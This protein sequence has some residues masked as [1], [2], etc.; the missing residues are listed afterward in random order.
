[1]A[2]GEH[3]SFHVW[4]QNALLY[5]H[6]P[7]AAVHSSWGFTTLGLPFSSA[8]DAAVAGLVRDRESLEAPLN[9]GKSDRAGPARKP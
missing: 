4:I 1:M 5:V 9:P 7:E 6:A 2:T 8:L 3:G